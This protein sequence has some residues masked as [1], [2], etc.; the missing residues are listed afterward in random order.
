MASIHELHQTISALSRAMEIRDPYTSGHQR[1][2][3]RLARRLAQDLGLPREQVEATRLSATLHDVGKIGTPAEILSKPA[4]LSDPEMALIRMH[5][6]VGAEIL[7][8][9]AF[10]FPI[11]TII[12]QHH[13]RLDG[14]GYPSGLLGNDILM[15]ARVVA[16]A[17]TLE[18]MVSHRPYRPA[19]GLEA[20][21]G[22]LAEGRGIKF[23]PDVVDCSLAL[24][25]RREIENILSD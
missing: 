4:K 6:D 12:V 15:E 18:A 17:D 21:A 11:C 14:S 20:A 10:E 2:V 8:D 9:I 16:V 13:E 24:C 25:R 7:A 3:S 22:A 23:D 1:R 19:R 5:S